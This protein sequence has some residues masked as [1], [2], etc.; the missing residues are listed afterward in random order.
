MN[1]SAPSGP[2]VMPNGALPPANSNSDSSPDMVMR[3]MRSSP[4][5]VNHIAPS[6]PAV[7][8][9]G[10][11]CGA[12]AYRVT[13]PSAAIR[14]ISPECTSVTHM[15]PSRPAASAYGPPSTSILSAL[16]KRG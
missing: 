3:P 14:A 16:L 8:T 10:R 11:D 13:P 5:R 7:I 9:D 12:T 1:H 6:G 2:A 15:A 4:L